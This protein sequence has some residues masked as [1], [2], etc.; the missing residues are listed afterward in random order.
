VRL[1]WQQR[2]ARSFPF[3]LLGFGFG[4]RNFAF[5]KTENDI[6]LSLGTVMATSG[7]ALSPNMGFHTS[8]A[9]AFLLT[10]FNVRLGQW[11]FNPARMVKG[12]RIP[13]LSL[14]YLYY[15]L[16]GLTKETSR[17][18]YLSDGGH[19]ENLGLYELIRREC[20]YIIVSDA[21]EDGEYRF[22]DLG[23][24]IEKCRVDFGV[25][26]TDLKTEK[27]RLEGDTGLSTGHWTQGKIR[28]KNKTGVIVYLKPSLTGDEPAD[29]R[30]YRAT[31]V[32]FPHQSTGD[33]WFDEAQ[34]EAYRAL[35]YHIGSELQ[36]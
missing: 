15:E 2:K 29:V 30:S 22:G 9:V 11:F 28:Y 8:S 32:A 6:P 7:A 4:E 13:R 36:R 12:D 34:F 31:H 18:V 5:S 27:I 19:F 21:S 33:Q 35:G 20:E 10:L 17:Y 14:F 3:T 25:E 24:A 1:D 23:G 16:F 26:I